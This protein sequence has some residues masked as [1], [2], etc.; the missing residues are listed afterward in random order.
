MATLPDVKD[1]MSQ[2]MSHALT[3]GLFEAVNG[4]EGDNAPGDGI[5]ATYLL[6]NIDPVPNRSGLATTSLRINVLLRMQINLQH[7]PQ[8]DVDILLGNAALAMVAAYN[9]AFSLE[10]SVMAID[11]LGA[12]GKDLSALFTYLQAPGA[13]V[14]RAAEINIPVIFADVIDQE[15]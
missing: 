13:T 8:D 10:G 15:A 9:G 7:E 14:F 11:L 1:L 2:L 5:T 6:G 12:D 3:S 4:H